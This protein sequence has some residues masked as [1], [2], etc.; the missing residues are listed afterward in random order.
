[1]L[2]AGNGPEVANQTLNERHRGGVRLHFIQPG[3]PV[4]NAFIE[5]FNGKFRD[6]CLNQHWFTSLTDA[7]ARIEVWRQDYNG[8]RPHSSLGGKTPTEFAA[9]MPSSINPG[10]F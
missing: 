9:L 4:Q 5:S 7:R 6:A 8:Q 1:V 10:G 3:K 2:V